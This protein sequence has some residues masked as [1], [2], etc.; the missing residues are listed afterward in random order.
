ME[1]QLFST[2]KTT[3]KVEVIGLLNAVERFL[4]ASPGKIVDEVKKV[5]GDQKEGEKKEQTK[6]DWRGS[7]YHI[8][9]GNVLNI[10]K[11]GNCRIE[12]IS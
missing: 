6:D 8:H 2:F 1:Y 11:K 7:D 3:S 12:N 10:W 5:E 9:C 4:G